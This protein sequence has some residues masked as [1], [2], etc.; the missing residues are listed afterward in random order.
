MKVI[1]GRYK[2]VSINVKSRIKIRPTTQRIKEWIFQIFEPYLPESYFLDL[3]AGSGNLGIEALSR[4]CKGAVFVDIFTTNLIRRNLNT[5]KSDAETKIFKDDVIRFLQRRFKSPFRFKVIAAD[6]PYEYNTFHSF[7]SA[8]Y[9]SDFL[10][11]EGFLILES[12]KH[13][14]LCLPDTFYREIR[15]KKFGE[16]IIKIFQRGPA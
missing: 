13:S 15:E 9:Q 14:E 12:G 7:L 1:A 4:G 11:P 6:P 5:V 10:L 3:F 16:T 2:G 8:V